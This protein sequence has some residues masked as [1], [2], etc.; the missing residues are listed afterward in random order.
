MRLMQASFYICL[1]LR[2]VGKLEPV[3]DKAAAEDFG[4]QL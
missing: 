2:S 1:Y 4:E 3:R